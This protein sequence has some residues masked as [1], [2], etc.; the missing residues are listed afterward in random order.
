VPFL[1]QF[2]LLCSVVPKFCAFNVSER[3]AG[4]LAYVSVDGG[5]AGW[6]WVG[7]VA[8]G[9]VILSSIARIGVV[10]MALISSACGLLPAAGPNSI[11]VDTG[12]AAAVPYALVKLTPQAVDVVAQYEPAGLAGA[13]SS[14][15]GPP[16]I[17]FGIGDIVAVTIFEAAAGGLFIPTEAG[18]RPGNFVQLPDET[19]DNGGYITV[20]YAG[21]VRAAGRTNV[22]VQND[23]V[24]RIKNRAIEP[25]V[26]VALAKQNTSLITVFGEVGT[27]IRYPAASLGAR[28]RV[29]DA[30]TRAGGIK[31]QGY[32]TWVMLER[33]GK[34]GTV[35]LANLVYEPSNNIFVQP[36]DRIYVY[37]ED[38][39]FIAFGASGTQGEFPFGAWRINL[40]EAV[41][42]AGGL[43]DGAADPGSV[44]L[45]RHEP[46]HVAELL[47]ADVSRFKGDVVPVIFSVSFRD[48][49]GYFLATKLQM[50]NSDVVFVA[51]A[52]AV[53]I[54]KF[55]TF[56][57]TVMATVSNEYGLYSIIKGTTSAASP[58]TATSITVQ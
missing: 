38:Q 33:N 22:E 7:T 45:Y 53:E 3:L 48:P 13:F 51:N 10:G 47:G 32:Q 57:N 28:D 36:G 1:P 4:P 9:S 12:I 43:N 41:A 17:R 34:R 18:V 5:Y 29:T 58:T 21:A 50:R 30:I 46:R 40:A 42:K 55:T 52:E 14:K 15:Q 39:K 8:Q 35:P 26:I 27:P 23:I 54:T 56:A 19:V 31:D 20:P 44:Y 2:W 25:Q 49:S 37:Q 16:N 24:E 6:C 11:A